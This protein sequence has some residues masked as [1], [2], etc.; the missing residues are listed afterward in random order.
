MVDDFLFFSGGLLVG[1]ILALRYIAPLMYMPVVDA[2]RRQV[3][4][5]AADD[6]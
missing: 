2:L 4:R 1:A 6:E 5:L 3:A